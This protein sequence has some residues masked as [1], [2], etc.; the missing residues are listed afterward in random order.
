[1]LTGTACSRCDQEPEPPNHPPGPRLALAEAEVTLKGMVENEK[2]HLTVSFGNTGQGML[3]ILR[4]DRSR[5]CHVDS[6]PAALDPGEQGQLQVECLAD[7]HGPVKE[8]IKVH[9]NDPQHPELELT[10]TGTV[11]PQLAFEPQSV[12]LELSYGEQRSRQVLLRGTRLG[13][14]KAELQRGALDDVSRVDPLRNDDG[15]IRGYRITCTGDKV[16]LHASSLLVSTG[17]SSPQTLSLS[18]ACRVEGTLEVSPSTPYFDLR[19][20]GTKEREIRVR[21]R[22]PTFVVDRV[23]ILD[24][25]F[26]AELLP[27]DADGSFPARVRV[28]EHQ[29]GPEARSATGTLLILSNDITQP[30]REVRLLGVG[31]VNQADGPGAPPAPVK[32]PDREVP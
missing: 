23:E 18:Y 3:Q 7:L 4:V 21:S 17:L 5:F 31:H 19:I 20:S 16:G 9:S 11:E 15:R 8:R 27:R 14:A 32:K 6:L 30:R 2:Q 10:L 12:N 29:I 28:L 25:P 22:Q 13:A 26:E 1:M 24:G